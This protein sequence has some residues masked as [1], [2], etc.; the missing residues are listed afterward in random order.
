MATRPTCHPS[1]CR[2]AVRAAGL[3]VAA[4]LAS[5]ASAQPLPA[6][7]P[8]AQAPVGP[9]PVVVHTA[10]GGFILGYDIDQV[11]DKGLLCEA[12]T[13][14][15]GHH[16]VAVETFDQRTGA[17]V[18]IVVQQL[19]SKN[20]Y[21]ALG[22]V[23]SHVGL[24]E[25]EH[26]T[27]LFVDK[28]QYFTLDPLAGG[29]LTDRWTPPL[30]TQQILLGLGRAQGFPEVAALGFDN[31]GAGGTF[32]FG[33]DVAANSFG[34]LVSLPGPDFETGHSPVVALD[35]VGHRAVLGTQGPATFGPPTLAT[36]NLV[37]SAIDAF[38]GLGIGFVNGIAVDGATGIACT[39]TEIDFR[40]QFT[41]LVSHAAF[42]VKL[43][44]ALSQAHS[45]KDVQCD[46]LH[47]LF[48]VGQPISSTAPTGSSLHVFDEQGQLVESLNG[49]QLPA[50]PACIALKPSR[51]TGFVLVA[52]DLTSL[53]S[54]TY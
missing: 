32:V 4:M 33:S 26:V 15:N 19:D 48:L 17:I 34:P 39:A 35:P 9:G 12:L 53:Q 11:G 18:K 27:D 30:G 43:P 21:L 40:V 49:F 41:D 13:L 6:Q 8:A 47:G 22:V 2:H 14:S 45:G 5:P 20:D 54:F 7:L 50:G 28:R 46:P 37:T 16:D 1:A 24:V 31:G 44:G 38:S 36:V 10:F 29:A 42:A 25:F 52:P 51:R 23:G 3:A